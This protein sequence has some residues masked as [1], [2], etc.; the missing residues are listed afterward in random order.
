MILEEP[1]R[2]PADV[3]ARYRAAGVIFRRAGTE[4]RSGRVHLAQPSSET[5]IAPAQR[6]T[7]IEGYLRRKRRDG[8]GDIRGGGGCGRRRRAGTG[9]SRR[10][11]RGWRGRAANAHVVRA[12]ANA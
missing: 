3:R 7:E 1:P 4:R 9:G 11:R 6:R 12:E 5:E 10:D 2:A 8:D